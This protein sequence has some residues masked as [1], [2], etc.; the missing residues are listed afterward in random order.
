[1]KY[2]NIIA[3]AAAALLIGVGAGAASAEEALLGYIPP[4]GAQPNQHVAISAMEKSG[5]PMGWSVRTLDPNLSADKQVAHIDTLLTLGA[6]AI[7]IEPLDENAIK[8]ALSRAQA[9]GV[10]V[11]GVNAAGE[12]IAST[13]WWDNIACR[14]GRAYDEQAD[15]IAKRRP[16]AKVII[17]GGPNAPAIRASIACFEKAAKKAGLTI[18]DR[19]DNLK[20]SSANAS[21]LA[22]DELVRFPDVDV[23]WAYN[24]GS[25]LGISAAA[26]GSGKQTYTAGTP[27]GL[28]IFG[29]NGD[30]DAIAAIR[31]GRVTGTW[32]PNPYALG[33][34][35]FTGMKNAIEKKGTPKDGLVVKM[36]LF[37][38]DNVGTYVPSAERGYTLDTIPLVK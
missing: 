15:W 26:I 18:I 11:V 7:A 36:D 32:D 5:A 35:I 23:F 27:D 37:T 24:D 3:S 19:V 29:V 12:G 14:E 1:M 2:V 6:K 8:G 13:V 33:L 25:A 28:M 10:P 30:K 16:N 20:D 17:M 34:A 9:Q 21:T 22:A 4:I 31:E 38:V